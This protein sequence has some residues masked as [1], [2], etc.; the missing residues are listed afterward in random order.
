LRSSALS[1]TMGWKDRRHDR[2]IERNDLALLF[3]NR[4]SVECFFN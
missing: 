2:A 1:C 3:L 4:V